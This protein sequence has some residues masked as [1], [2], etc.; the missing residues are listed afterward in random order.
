[1]SDFT[2]R[3]AALHVHPVKS[4]AGIAVQEAFVEETGLDLDRA[5]MVVDRDGEFLSQRE[6]PAMARIVPALKGGEV[7]LRAPGMLALHLSVDRVE[8]PLR[9]RLWD[10]ELPAYDMGPLAAQWMSD[11]LGRPGLRLARFDTEQRRLS[12]R[13]WT[14]DVEALNAFSDGYPLL[15]AGQAS[16]DDLNT[17]LAA[18]GAAPVDMRRFRANLV[19]EGLDP[20]AEDNVRELR[21]ATPEGPVVLRLVKPCVR[22]SIPN[23]DP[24]TGTTG[25]EP[26]DTLA[27][28]RAD[29]RMNGGITFGM[30]TVI[31][32]GIGRT[33]RV[34]QAVEGDYAFD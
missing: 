10:D 19:L 24:D 22:C 4:C 17:R 27:G 25:H 26:G 5:W 7:V 3:L 28:F 23:V 30:N 11:C 8:Q 1:M 31:V 21:I 29:A 15:V 33:L 6:L 9:V 32:E 12:S 18:R 13:R 20:W 16:L 2:A 14:G 34:G